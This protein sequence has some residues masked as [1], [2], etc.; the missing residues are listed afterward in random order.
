MK[1]KGLP[2]GVTPEM[3]KQPRDRSASGARANAATEGGG[4]TRRRSRGRH[5][6]Q[7]N[8]SERGDAPSQPP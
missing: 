3:A 7:S 1:G 4:E 6:S 2:N 8:N 5:N